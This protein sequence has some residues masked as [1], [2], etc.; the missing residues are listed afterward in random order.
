MVEL[1]QH[2]L[3]AVELYP[4]KSYLAW[5]VGTGK[6]RGALAISE[7]H[8]FSRLLVV[9]PRSAHQIWDEES[10]NFN[11]F[12]VLR[13]IT[14]EFFRDKLREEE[15]RGYDLVIFDE[16]HRLSYIRTK[17]TRKA[18]KA[19]RFIKNILML[20]GTPADKLHKLYSQLLILTNWKD[21]MFK[22]FPTYTAFIHHYFF[23]D[24]YNKPQ[25]VKHSR[26]KRELQE[27][28]QKYAYIV[29]KEDVIE[30]PDLILQE[31][32]LKPIELKVE[33]IQNVLSQFMTEYRLSSCLE[34]KIE[35]VIDLLEQE[36]KVVVFSLFKDFVKEIGKRL[37]N[38]V[39]AFTS[40]TPKQTVEKAIQLQDK[41]IITTY[42]L[43]E[44]AN[45]QKNYDTIV[46]ASQPLS[47]IQYEQAVGRVYRSGQKN[48]VR[49]FKLLQNKID[50]WVN[51]I[52]N[53]KQD[54]LEYLKQ[55][56]KL[57]M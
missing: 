35:W 22:R 3:K 5:E 47:Y 36:E 23:V 38:K 24:N 15:L 34:D 2:Q 19:R 52:I 1:Y 7:K 28:F 32:K 42:M 41:P 44:G 51:W 43:S 48:K 16:A 11:G 46:F 13:V 30:L 40:E 55:G 45:L 50:Y 29:R 39:Y 54:V 8:G 12:N 56:G 18:I 49:I 31:V 33:S 57:W 26:Y 17:W 4:E 6:T 21:E 37:G 14:Y 27:W 53:Q 20:S 9:A 10:K 25:K